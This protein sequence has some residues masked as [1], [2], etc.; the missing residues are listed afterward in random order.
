M[1]VQDCVN[2]ATS[3]DIVKEAGVNLKDLMEN[4]RWKFDEVLIR[5]WLRGS[6]C[7]LVGI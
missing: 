2:E 6:F 7:S 5:S 1:E 3:V 4:L